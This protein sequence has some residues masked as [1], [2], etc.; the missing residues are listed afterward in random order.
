MAERITNEG[1]PDEYN[2]MLEYLARFI[3]IGGD[4]GVHVLKPDD[5]DGNNGMVP[6]TRADIENMGVPFMAVIRNKNWLEITP[7]DIIDMF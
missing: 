4:Y 7:A 2:D 5:E 1:M 6:L 3:E